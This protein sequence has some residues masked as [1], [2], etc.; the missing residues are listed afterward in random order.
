MVK[1]YT[2]KCYTSNCTDSDPSHIVISISDELLQKLE[3]TFTFLKEH[4]LKSAN[5]SHFKD[6]YFVFNPRIGENDS[7]DFVESIS[8]LELII[9]QDNTIRVLFYTGSIWGWSDLV[10]IN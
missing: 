3:K 1:E 7:N 8:N 2:V 4:G 9:F 5:L 10:T 6:W